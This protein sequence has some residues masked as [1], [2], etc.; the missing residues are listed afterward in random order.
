MRAFLIKTSIFILIIGTIFLGILSLNNGETDPY[1]LKFTSPRQQNLILG[2]SR[3]A[4][5]IQPSVLKSTLGVDFFNFSFTL[6]H[7]PYGP[8]YYN[9]INEKLDQNSKNGIS[10][11]SIDPWSISSTT[12]DPNDVDNF[13]ENELMLSKL[14]IFNMNPNFDY[15]INNMQGKYYKV[16]SK[17]PNVFLH[18][19]GWLEVNVK[20]DSLSTTKRTKNKIAEY[21]KNTETYQLSSLRL[22]YLVKTIE[23]LKEHG[24]VYLVRL[25]V[26]KPILEMETNYY[27]QFDEMI[28]EAIEL[29]DGYLDLTLVPDN[30]VYNDG[31]HLSPKSSAEVSQEIAKWINTQISFK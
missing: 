4:Q 13:R 11:L 22:N 31:N 18:D 29:S 3:S 8:V 2:T 30:N 21:Q 19:D 9:A 24:K 7:S 17:D 6:A 26:S 15:L 27:G 10:I 1:Y 28:S 23:L 14:N 20:L 25:P 5:G 12:A 16:F